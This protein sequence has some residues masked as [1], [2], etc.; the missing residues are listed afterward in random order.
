MENSEK[1]VNMTQNMAQA[2][3]HFWH[4]PIVILLSALVGFIGHCA[5]AM[6]NVFP[7]RVTD[8]DAL[9]M[10]ISNG[11][12]GEDALL[13]TEYNDGGYYQ[14]ESARNIFIYCGTAIF[15]G[16]IA[17]FTVPGFAGGLAALI[18]TSF[19]WIGETASQRLAE[20]GWM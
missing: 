2:D 20:Q 9:D 15:V 18:E 5:R 7:D 1:I 16:T 6:F 17:W 12:N 13:G 3:V 4:L 8:S 10:V 14:F 11:Y 19:A